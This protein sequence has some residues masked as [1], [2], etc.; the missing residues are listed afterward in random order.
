MLY[1]FATSANKFCRGCDFERKQDYCCTPPTRK[2]SGTGTGAAWKSKLPISIRRTPRGG[3]AASHTVLS[4]LP[5]PS[6]RKTLG[7]DASK[8]SIPT[9]RT[10]TSEEAITKCP[11]SSPKVT[12]TSVP[13]SPA[14][15]EGR[16]QVKKT[17]F[18]SSGINR[19]AY[20][21]K[22]IEYPGAILQKSAT[23]PVS[24]VRGTA[25]AAAVAQCQTR[26]PI[27]KLVAPKTGVQIKDKNTM[28]A[29]QPAVASVIPNV[30][31]PLP[32]TYFPVKVCQG[33]SFKPPPT[34]PQKSRGAS[35][36][37][38]HRHKDAPFPGT[39][40]QQP[41]LTIPAGSKCYRKP[42]PG[43]SPL[44]QCFIQEEVRD[45]AV[46]EV[47]KKLGPKGRRRQ[48]SNYHK[49]PLGPRVQ[50]HRAYL[51]YGERGSF[52]GPYLQELKDGY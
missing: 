29:S 28:L 5:I 36:L 14:A 49:F 40:Q 47:Q 22:P 46:A 7:R 27:A 11:L 50:L 3:A 52:L 4:Q 18:S 8:H 37:R 13:S 39:P 32:S 43:A 2:V 51:R 25:E 21:A 9:R 45:M 19:L 33:E 34:S 10:K 1:S 48:W 20:V 38:K 31:M 6:P 24:S 35:Y 42:S 23:P 12:G 41:K 30:F 26:L 17:K 44:I 15:S 16:L